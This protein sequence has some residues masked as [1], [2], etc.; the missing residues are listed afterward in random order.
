MNKD[1]K[2]T[3]QKLLSETPIIESNLTADELAAF[4]KNIPMTQTL[5][6]SI[7]DKLMFLGSDTEETFFHMLLEPA[8]ETFMLKYAEKTMQDLDREFPPI[9]K[10]I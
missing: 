1:A 6:D 9:E 2:N 7:L 10:K 8:Y 4:R 5:Y 3:N